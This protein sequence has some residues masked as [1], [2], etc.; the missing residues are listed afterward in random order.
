MNFTEK[1]DLLMKKNGL[2]KHTLAQK[3][4]VKYTTIDAFYKKGY[5][6]MK[7]SNFKAIC[8]YFGVTM[9]SMARD[10]I[11]EIEY[12]NLK[13][14]SSLNIDKE[15]ELLIRC[16]READDRDKELAMRAVRADEQKE[17]E[18]YYDLN[19]RIG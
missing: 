16:Y 11:E 17:L 6:N 8:D 3:T 13:K 1:L 7:L 18:H 14:S 19:S 12:Y 10:D 5:S 4:G 15:E 2:N 9:D